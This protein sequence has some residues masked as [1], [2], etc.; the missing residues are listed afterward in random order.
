M[1][2]SRPLVNTLP[3]SEATSCPLFAEGPET[4][5]PSWSIATFGLAVHAILLAEASVRL[6]E[7]ALHT[8]HAGLSLPQWALMVIS[9]AVFGYLEGYRVLH[10][11]FFPHVLVRA[12]ELAHREKRARDYLSAPFYV[13]SL[14]QAGKRSQ[15]RAWVGASLIVGAIFL[16][17][18]LPEPYRGIIDAGV[19][20]ALTIGLGSLIL[21]YVAT[22]R[23]KQ[24]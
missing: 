18:A 19:A 5:A 22:V 15:Q 1:S 2:E 8:M 17:R 23:S 21:R 3:Q 20:V 9:I 4:R 13:V 10:C 7:R 11:R 16:V 12:S 14:V 24:G 6:G